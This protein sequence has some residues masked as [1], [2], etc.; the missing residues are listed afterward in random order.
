MFRRAK[1]AAAGRPVNSALGRKTREQSER[2]RRRAADLVARLAVARRES[3]NRVDIDEAA[4]YPYSALSR[5]L[6]NVLIALKFPAKLLF[7]VAADQLKL[8]STDR[9][10]SQAWDSAVR[11]MLARDGYNERQISGWM[12]DATNRPW[13]DAKLSQQDESRTRGL[14]E[15]T[16]EALPLIIKESH[17]ADA[18]REFLG[19]S[20]PAAW[21][22]IGAAVWPAKRRRLDL[23]CIRP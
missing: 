15:Q 14:I 9:H 13:L 23:T 18:R 12:R 16:E 11:D 10:R 5:S 7:V 21:L 6:C 3:G 19:S 8:S 22:R 17:D 2:E 4:S 20:C 1:R